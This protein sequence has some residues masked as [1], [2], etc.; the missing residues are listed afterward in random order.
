MERHKFKGTSEIFHLEFCPRKDLNQAHTLTNSLAYGARKHGMNSILG[1]LRNDLNDIKSTT[2]NVYSVE[3]EW[4]I[5]TKVI[6]QEGI[7][8]YKGL[9]TGTKLSMK[10]EVFFK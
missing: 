1:D 5:I 8:A 4:K 7:T 2:E 10:A 6:Y 3:H 9:I